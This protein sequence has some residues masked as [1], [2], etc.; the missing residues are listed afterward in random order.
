[1]IPFVFVYNQS[2]LLIL[3]FSITEFVWVLFRLGLAIALLATAVVG[4]Q[5]QNLSLVSRVLR[6]VAAIAVVTTIVPAQIAGL[7]LG[8]LLLLS[9]WRSGRVSPVQ[10]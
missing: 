8:G 6:A 4:Y 7:V 10:A 2:L 3:E 5:G 1:M 9:A